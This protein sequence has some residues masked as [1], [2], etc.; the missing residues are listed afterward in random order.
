MR[1]VSDNAIQSQIEAMKGT[2]GS[3]SDIQAILDFK[4]KELNLLKQEVLSQISSG[5][6]TLALDYSHLP[7]ATL[8]LDS[9]EAL[10]TLLNNP[11]VV[12]VYENKQNQMFLNESLPLINQPAAANAGYWGGGTVAV[13]D[14]G[15]DYTNPAF[16]DCV[17]GHDCRVAVAGDFAPDDGQLDD[18][19]HGT[20]VAAIVLGVAPGAYIAAID[21]FDGPSA[22]DEVIINAINWAIANQ[23][24]YN[25]VAM[26]LSLGNSQLHS[27]TECRDSPYD[28]AFASA[29]E[30]GILPIV[31]AGNEARKNGI[32]Y[33]ACAPGAVSVGAVYDDY[34]GSLA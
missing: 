16:G 21:V 29:R 8:R 31:A 13:L 10:S 27:D 28:Q 2:V 11:K 23:G 7:M 24:Y 19:G 33:P 26:N 17:N 32:S 34:M 3:K 1:T 15:V 12:R 18:N 22:P 6:I 30:V 9:L 25:I 20:N 14:T 5:D 4:Q